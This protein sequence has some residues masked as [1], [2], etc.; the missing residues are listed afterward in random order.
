MGRHSI[1]TPDNW[2]LSGVG[3]LLQQ[4]DGLSRQ[5]SLLP[6]Q[7]GAEEAGAGWHVPSAQLPLQQNTSS[8]QK[9]PLARHSG[10]E[11]DDPV[12]P[13][14]I[15]LPHKLS[16]QSSS[17]SHDS[18]SALQEKSDDVFPSSTTPPHTPPWHRL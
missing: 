8:A 17:T 3:P 11:L 9:A 12:S 7:A 10:A 18:P 16:Q 15:P 4:P 14:Q 6:K 1:S 2:Q 5:F 13:P